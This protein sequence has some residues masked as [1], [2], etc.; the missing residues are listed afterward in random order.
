MQK[1]PDFADQL[2]GD[3]YATTLSQRLIIPHLIH[4]VIKAQT[5]VHAMD[6]ALND[7]NLRNVG[8]AVMGGLRR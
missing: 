2:M 7:Y 4:A 5:S 3:T 8:I 1:T 6:E